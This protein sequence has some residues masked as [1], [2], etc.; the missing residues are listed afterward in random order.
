M[1]ELAYS[2]HLSSDKNRKSSSR[3]MA[4][5]N[6]SGSTSLSNNAIQNARGLSRVDKHNYR[7][8]DNN[9][10]LIEIIR[11]SS[12]LYEDVKKLYEEEFKEAVEEY[13]KE[14]EIKGRNDRK[15]TDYFKKISDNSKNDLACEIIIELGD[16]K[17]WD[18]KDDNFKHKMTNVFK[19]QVNDLEN[20]IPDFK[21]ASAIIHYDETSPH[22]HIVG[23]PIKYKNKNGMKKQVG[24][25]DVFT[26]DSL[27]KL[28]DK[29]RVLCIA[30]FNKEYGLNDILKTKQKGRNKDINVKDMGNYIEM[31]EQLNKDRK[32]LEIASKKSSELDKNTSEIKDIVDNLKKAPVVK[33]IY[34]ISESDKNKIID[35]IDK[36][37]NTNKDFKRTEKLSVTL[38]NVDT[39]LKENKEKIKILTEN[40]EALSLKVNTLSK[41]VENKDKE[42]KELKKENHN[43]KQMADYFKDLFSRL[44]NFIK[45]KM[46]GKDKEREDYWNFSKDLYEHGIFSDETIESIQDD[47][48]WSKDNDKD[49]EY[50][51]DDFEI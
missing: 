31:K 33:N 28:Q 38:N 37:D 45:H 24:K 29:M 2:L 42:I 8:Y 39:E 11:G 12:S 19:E 5:S 49:K 20:L 44:V 18:T 4:K 40:N 43:L 16:K 48:K 51:K 50:D 1:S 46:F 13:N 41:S 30:S 14:Q 36:V 7:K 6:K 47:Y 9:Q 10:D 22:L 27:R 15:I 26:R 3:N 17:Y 23:V 21:V 32:A 25:G 34:T 35:Y